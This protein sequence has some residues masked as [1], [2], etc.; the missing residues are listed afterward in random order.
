MASKHHPVLSLL[1][2][3]FAVLNG[4][5]CFAVNGVWVLENT[6]L[7]KDGT[8]NPLTGKPYWSKLQRNTASHA[9]GTRIHWEDPPHTIQYGAEE[10]LEIRVS[11]SSPYDPDDNP[12]AKL[13]T[14]SVTVMA[15]ENSGREVQTVAGIDYPHQWTTATYK[16]S[17]LKRRPDVDMQMEDFVPTRQSRLV[18]SIGGQQL[19]AVGGGHFNPSITAKQYY[20][21]KFVGDDP[22][23]NEETEADEEPGEFG[24]KDLPP[25][26]FWGPVAVAGGGYAISRIIKNRRKKRKE[27]G[28]DDDP[29]DSEQEK[30]ETPSTYRM[31]LYK[32]FGNSLRV[33]EQPKLIG[34]RIEE[35]KPPSAAFPQGQRIER[36]DMTKTIRISEGGNIELLA[37]GMSGKY[38]CARIR[39]AEKSTASPPDKGSVIFTFQGPGGT[40][41]DKVVFKIDSEQELIFAQDNVTFVAGK[42]DT[43]PVYFALLGFGDKP[44][45]DVKIERDRNNS[46]SASPVR[47]HEKHEQIWCLDLTDNH[48]SSQE[49]IPGN[50]DNF[51]LTITAHEKLQDGSERRVS[52][53]LPV[54]RFYEGLRLEIG[55][56]K[57]YPVQ[58]GTEDIFTTEKM[59]T[60]ETKDVEIARTRLA[61]TLFAWDK[62]SGDIGTPDPDSLEITIEDVPDSLCWY[63]KK[64]ARIEN[65]VSAL[66]LDIQPVNGQPASGDQVNAML[67]THLFQIVPSA[68]MLSPNRCQ[69]RISATATFQ[70]RDFK[71]EQVSMVTSMPARTGSIEELEKAAKRDTFITEDLIRMRAK[72]LFHPDS[73]QMEP[74]INKFSLL[75]E[76]YHKRFGYDQYEYAKAKNLYLR[77]INGEIGSM[78]VN[79]SVY[80]WQEIYL[81]E[82]FDLT[83]AQY[84]EKEPKTI[85]DRIML[86]L[87]TLGYSELLYYTPK[88]FLLTCKKAAEHQDAGERWHDFKVGAAFGFDEGIEYYLMHK[89]MKKVGA[90]IRTT[91]FGK[92]FS[93]MAVDIAKTTNNIKQSLCKSYSTVNYAFKFVDSA[94]KILSFRFRGRA[95]A[96]ANSRLEAGHKAVENSP[97]FQHL[98]KIAERAQRDGEQKAKAFLEGCKSKTISQQELTKLASA[99]QNDRFAK[100]FMNSSHVTGQQRGR[101][102]ME[103]YLLAEKTKKAVRTRYARDFNVHESEVTFFTATG[104]K[105]NNFGYA[106]KVG[107]DF[108]HTDCIRGQSLP[109]EIANKY[110]NEEYYFQVT[111]KRAPSSEVANAFAKEAEQ[112]AVSTFGPESFQDNLRHVLDPSLADQA[113]PNAAVVKR[114]QTYKVVEPL[115]AAEKAANEAYRCTDPV[116]KE[117]LERQA[118]SNFRE[119]CYQYTKGYNRTLDP[120]LKV[121]EQN[122]GGIEKNLDMRKVEATYNLY[123]EME[124]V[125]SR[126]KEGDATAILDMYVGSKVQGSNLSKEIN[127]SFSLI[128]DVDRVIQEN[129]KMPSLD[130]PVGHPEATFKGGFEE[131]FEEAFQPDDTDE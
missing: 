45:F 21:Y 31:I 22:V 104:N 57:A 61:V 8:K 112:T 80:S 16:S 59:P 121:I 18:I 32:D 94:N 4:G 103:V 125:V 43:T 113:L 40:L 38:R 116:R 127:D 10:D 117:L 58:K 41:N 106:E 14:A 91:Q 89:A 9:N 26:I 12:A 128:T 114:V 83:M 82:A 5:T 97:Q 3:L 65:P 60:A 87:V 71:A 69:A 108:D 39:A 1:F 66:G 124:Q 11:I 92:A 72:L 44:E 35:V 20:Y 107:M 7:S 15:W 98:K 79:E 130:I 77:F 76:S 2:C 115:E 64:D 55:H 122:L 131:G 70:G 78:Y 90:K 28:G 53:S 62:Q 85:Q 42:N 29:G 67:N 129:A 100:N 105:Q 126:S 96:K 6:E 52:G 13:I 93:E 48:H 49:D 111:G 88:R 46:F 68:I 75:L 81:G 30:Q 95:R 33:G 51:D 24:W 34:A 23:Y 47:P 56:I 101:F 110:W 119:S 120:K 84:Q 109:E 73:L 50:I 25:A 63:G 36:P 86:G 123:G 99:V 37:T 54:H 17:L 19:A 27:E 102:N 118:L 74:L